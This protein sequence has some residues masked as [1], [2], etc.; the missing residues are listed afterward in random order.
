L[1]AESPG[2][3]IDGVLVLVEKRCGDGEGVNRAGRVLVDDR[4]L[5]GADELGA[6]S[7][8]GRRSGASA[9]RMIRG[10][11]GTSGAARVRAFRPLVDRRYR[12]DQIVWRIVLRRRWRCPAP[13]AKATLWEVAERDRDDLRPRKAGHPAATPWPP[14]KIVLW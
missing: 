12:L 6:G 8:A 3:R 10:W 7:V 1:G 9:T 4:V 13:D 2:Q 11:R 14:L 5:K